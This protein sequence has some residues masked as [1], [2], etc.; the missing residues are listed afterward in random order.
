[1]LATWVTIFRPAFGL[2]E[3][4]PAIK[5]DTCDMRLWVLV[6]RFQYTGLAVVRRVA[7]AVILCAL[8]TVE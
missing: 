7:V 3:S 5:F 2:Y 4:S 1:M 8:I 6:T